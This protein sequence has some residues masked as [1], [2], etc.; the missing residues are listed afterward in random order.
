MPYPQYPLTLHKTY[1]EQGFFNLGV[2]VERYVRRDDGTVRL[3]LGACGRSLSGRV[4]RRWNRNGTPRVQGGAELR[5]WSQ[6]E[7]R[8]GEA[9]L[10]EI[11]A[12]DEMRLRRAR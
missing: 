10:V 9:V 4:S 11:V 8:H 1:Y 12:P 2:D 3:R 5:N 7:F 6:R